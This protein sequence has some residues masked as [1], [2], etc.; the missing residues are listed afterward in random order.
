MSTG[1]GIKRVQI[2]VLPLMS[3]VTSS[4][5]LSF[6]EPQLKKKKQNWGEELVAYASNPSYLGGRDQENLSL[7]PA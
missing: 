5:L 1:V 4:R 3:C 7:R 6:S 2:L